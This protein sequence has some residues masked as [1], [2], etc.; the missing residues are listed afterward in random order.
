MKAKG[1]KIF[2]MVFGSIVI[3]LGILTIVA[4][5]AGMAGMDE[6]RAYA[7]PAVDLSRIPD[8]DYA[9]ACAIGR[10]AM[11]VQVSVKNHLV[12]GVALSEKDRANMTPVLADSLNPRVVGQAHPDFDAVTGASITGKAYFIAVADALKKG[13][14]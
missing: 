8:G 5:S 1:L 6:V 13:M 2:L 12:T 11:T 9:G 14:P 10:F 3:T 4:V 7:I